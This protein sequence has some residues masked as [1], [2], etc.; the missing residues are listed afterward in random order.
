MSRISKLSDHRPF[1]VERIRQDFPILTRRVHDAPLV[2]LDNAATKQKP[3]SV[4]DAITECY[5]TSYANVHRG[6]HTLSDETTTAFENARARIATFVN[7]SAPE[8]VVFTKG[9]TEAIN[10]V[11]HSFGYTYLKAGDEII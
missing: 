8:C 11:A 6:I 9:A 3:R 2:Y 1:D 5:E 7:A 4:I 10:L